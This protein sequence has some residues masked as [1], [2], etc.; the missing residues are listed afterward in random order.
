MVSEEMKGGKFYCRNCLK[1]LM[2]KDWVH[3]EC[4]FENIIVFRVPPIAQ[5]FSL[6]GRVC[7]KKFV[8][9]IKKY[10]YFVKPSNFFNIEGLFPF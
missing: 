4:Y 7:H 8:A 2:V 6:L 9:K 10:F 5:K 3:K 1:L